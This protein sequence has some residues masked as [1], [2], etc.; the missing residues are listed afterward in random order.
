MGPTTDEQH[1]TEL[2]G[3]CKRVLRALEWSVTEDRLSHDDL[4]DLLKGAILK[5]ELGD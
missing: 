3:A 4:I 5:A 2:L 1:T